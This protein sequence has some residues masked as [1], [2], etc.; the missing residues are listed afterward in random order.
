[1]SILTLARHNNFLLLVQV[2][3]VALGVAATALEG[4]RGFKN[5]PQGPGADLTAGREVVESG[6]ELMALVRDEG[7]AIHKRPRIHCQLLI[8]FNL[9]FIGIQ[10]LGKE[11]K[12]ES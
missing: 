1:M 7:G 6:D 12:G 11:R 4:R 3:F 2:I 9:A 5:V 10:D 8:T